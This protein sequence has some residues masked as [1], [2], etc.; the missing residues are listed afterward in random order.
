MSKKEIYAWSSLASS[1]VLLGLYLTAVF[2]WPTS[3]EEHAGYITG[4]F[5]KVLAIAVVVELL[6]EVL[7]EFNST[8]V[9]EDERDEKIQAKGY[10]NAYY[11]LMGSIIVL[12]FNMFLNNLGQEVFEDQ[13]VLTVPVLSLH[14]LIII[15]F[16]ADITKAGTQIYYYRKGI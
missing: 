6:I 13:L 10:K 4:L 3:L 8:E 5:W 9:F 16:M 12:A 11:F 14:L 1:I 15:F 2:G 7:K